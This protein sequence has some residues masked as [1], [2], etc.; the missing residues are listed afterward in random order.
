MRFDFSTVDDKD[1]F[2]SV[3]E[4]EYLCRV[5]EV[6]PGSARDGSE[7]WSFRLEVVEGPWA[8]RTAGWDSL[9]WSE[10]GVFRVKRV[11]EAFGYPVSGEVEIELEDLVGRRA[12]VQLE[13]EEWEDPATGRRQVRMQV[14]YLGYRPDGSSSAES[15]ARAAARRNALVDGEGVGR[16]S[17]AHEPDP[18]SEA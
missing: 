1:S 6:R 11:L 2:L 12:H 18:F 14:P 4:G 3:P 17:C 15:T 10:R 7:R 16:E 9:T 8:G 5:A 13:T